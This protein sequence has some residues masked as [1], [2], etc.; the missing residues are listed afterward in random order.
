MVVLHRGEAVIAVFRNREVEFP[1]A[2]PVQIASCNRGFAGDLP[3]NHANPVN[4]SINSGISPTSNHFPVLELTPVTGVYHG[5]Y[6]IS[7]YW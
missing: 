1:M 6:P 7:P 5:S 2:F 3:G 4:L